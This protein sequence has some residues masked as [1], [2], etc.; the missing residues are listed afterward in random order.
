[1]V[2]TAYVLEKNAYSSQPYFART[3]PQGKSVHESDRASSH[4]FPSSERAGSVPGLVQH[5]VVGPTASAQDGNPGR[6]RSRYVLA[7]H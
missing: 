5:L 6:R 2:L 3:E 1:M 7:C 4:A